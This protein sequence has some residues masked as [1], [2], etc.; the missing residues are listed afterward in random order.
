M[1]SLPIRPRW[2]TWRV[3]L[4]CL[5][6]LLMIWMAM[7]SYANLRAYRQRIDKSDQVFALLS[8]STDLFTSLQEVE[9]GK[10]AY[11]LTGKKSY[12][13][14]YYQAVKKTDGHF[15]RMAL[16]VGVIPNGPQRLE[17]LRTLCSQKLAEV[18]QVIDLYGSQ[19]LAGAIELMEADT[20][21]RHMAQIREELIAFLR[22]AYALREA[23][24]ES[25][26]GENTRRTLVVTLGA[27]ALF[28]LLAFATVLIEREHQRQRVYASQVEELNETLEQ[29]V[30]DR[31]EA[32]EEANRE[33]EAF[34]YSVSHDLRAPLRSVEGFSKILTRDYVN[35]PLDARANDLMRRMSA[36]TV[37]MGQLIDDLLNLSR[38]SRGSLD[39]TDFDVSA[40]ASVVAQELA[41]QNPGRQMDV[42]IEPDLRVNGDP[43]LLRLAIENLFAN[44]WKFTRPRSQPK[45]MFGRSASEGRNAFFVRD[46]GVG[47]DMAHSA[48]LFLAFQRL[49][50]DS[51]FEGTGIGLA[52]VQRV[53]HCHGGRI[54]AESSP[55]LGATFYFTI[56]TPRRTVLEESNKIDLDG[57]GQS[58]RR[59]AHA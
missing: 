5:P 50:H 15:Q 48:Q 8:A 33:L 24:R 32:L 6:L 58:G 38:I 51:E 4:L 53:I 16:L 36:S 18:Q 11:L 21:Q 42:A 37:R 46:N 3:G 28:L 29:K 7:S 57:G 23:L 2:L 39:P 47:F 49:H 22:D 43:R 59:T 41:I 56:E 25:A 1:S 40:L 35:R 44:A 13:A 34:C 10:R 20:G 19:N 55:G 12:L 14:P 30:L 9:S 31:T 27:T 52:T 54:W 45:V 17:R 26:I